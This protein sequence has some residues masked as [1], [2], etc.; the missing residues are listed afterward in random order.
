[1]RLN[2][3][4]KSELVIV[5]RLYGALYYYSPHNFDKVQLNTYFQ[6]DVETP[7]VDVNTVLNS[8]KTTNKDDLT[9]EYRKLFSTHAPYIAPPWGSVYLDYKNPLNGQSTLRYCDFIEH[10]G[11]KLRNQAT[12]P[13]DHIGLMLMVLAMLLDDEQNQH[14]KELLEEYLLP[15]FHFFA[16]RIQENT[17][18]EAYRKL[19][20]GTSDLLSLLQNK[21]D[22]STIIK[23]NF[24]QDI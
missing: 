6:H 18:Q 1:M 23:N 21:F 8:F 15:W 20:I 11:L 2:E 19:T 5:C 12:D 10:C 16:A 4:N 9:A 7:I 13:E 22:V 14:I 24:L 3:L 17:C